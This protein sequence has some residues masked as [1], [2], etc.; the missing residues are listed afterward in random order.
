MS[1][2]INIF[3][4]GPPGSGKTALAEYL[5]GQSK[6]GACINIDTLRHF[7][8]G[9]VCRNPY[10]QAFVDQK[11]LSYTNTRCLID[12]Y[13]KSNIET[14]VADL[15]LDPRI[16]NV[17]QSELGNLENSYH[18]VLIPSISVAKERNNKRDKWKIMEEDVIEKYYKFISEINLP[19]DWIVIDNTNQTLEESARDVLERIKLS[20]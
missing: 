17:Y 13:R 2:P 11:K 3:F 5:A 9:G 7:Q 18:F 20:R 10:E 12:N 19:K 16:I 6:N 14:Y 8:I 4:N 1:V 15:V